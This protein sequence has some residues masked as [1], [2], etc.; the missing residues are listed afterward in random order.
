MTQ[1]T[2]Q[3]L[4]NLLQRGEITEAEFAQYAKDGGTTY[5]RMSEEELREM[6]AAGR[7]A[8]KP[9]REISVAGAGAAVVAVFQIIFG[10]MQVLMLRN[11]RIERQTPIG[12]LTALLFEAEYHLKSWDISRRLE[13]GRLMILFGAA[14]LACTVISA[15]LRRSGRTQAVICKILLTAAWILCGTLLL[16][17]FEYMLREIKFL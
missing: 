4:Q 7:A 11:V 10:V 3:R 12:I 5:D 8:D 15:I 6:I 2:M 1:V 17:L 13:D 16:P 14:S 9:E